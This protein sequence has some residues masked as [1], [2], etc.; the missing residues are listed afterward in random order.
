MTPPSI[1]RDGADDDRDGA[2][3]DPDVRAAEYVLGTLNA[4]E[5]VEVE[6]ALGVDPALRSAVYAW[7]DRLLGLAAGVAPVEPAS[8][9]WAAIDAR[10]VAGTATSR[11]TAGAGA[12]SSAAN[13][14][15]WRQLRRWQLGSAAGLA[16]SLVLA[17]AL[18]L[19][20]R[21]PPQVRYVAV[22]QSP[23]DQADG[24]VVE[25]TSGG[26]LRLL[27]VATGAPVPAGKSLQFW[28]KAVGASAPTS[29]GLVRVG[30]G[31]EL[32]ASALPSLGPRQ[33]FELTLEPATG[34]PIGRPTGPIVFVG[35][36]VQL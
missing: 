12:G 24:W 13:D 10:L 31:V 28:T 14:P 6:R 19:Q 23:V 5:R 29:L 34:S 7:Q 33:L 1:D 2:G 21:A 3:D 22:L 26:A 18:V 30:Q 36:S 35:R 9:A 25:A 15:Q 4:A 16:A 27:P 17:T 11:D 8:G 20:L 32:P